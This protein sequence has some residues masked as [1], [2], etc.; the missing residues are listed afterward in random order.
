[1]KM[2]EYETANPGADFDEHEKQHFDPAVHGSRPPTIVDIQ[3]VVPPNGGSGSSSS[4][5][6]KQQQQHNS[7]DKDDDDD[8]SKT[9]TTSPQ[10]APRGA[11][12]G[13]AASSPAD[14]SSIKRDR[15]DVYDAA[16]GAETGRV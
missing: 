13:V 3:E 6:L 1:M 11:R 2:L 10:H 8:G 12:K 14:A 9:V 7:S 16:P 4:G 5:G 15:T